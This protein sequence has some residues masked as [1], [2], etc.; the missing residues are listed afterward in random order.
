MGI[1]FCVTGHKSTLCQ[2]LTGVRINSTGKWSSIVQIR[3]KS[4]K[5][6]GVKRSI[7]WAIRDRTTRPKL[8]R[9]SNCDDFYIGETK[10][11]LHDRK[12][13]HFEA[14][15]KDRHTSAI[16]DSISSTD[17]NIKWD[18]FET[19]TTGKSDIH[20]RIKETLLIRDLKPALDENV[21]S[22]KLFLYQHHVVP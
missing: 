5:F 3:V 8:R 12:P 20:C 18:H 9:C 14:L 16:A 6:A 1:L 15:T 4:T 17:H 22:E 19:L 10:R 11:R 13:E 21:G 7:P 2:Y